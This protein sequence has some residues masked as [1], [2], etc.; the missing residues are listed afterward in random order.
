[1]PK[2]LNKEQI[3]ALT[4]QRL[5]AWYGSLSRDCNSST[6]WDSQAQQDQMCWCY[7]EARREL[8]RRGVRDYSKTKSFGFTAPAQAGNE[9]A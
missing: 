5:L 2:A 9:A 3:K 4:D 1:M 6:R 8:T 7:H